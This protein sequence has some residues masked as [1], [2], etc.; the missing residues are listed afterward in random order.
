MKLN[1]EKIKKELK[2]DERTKTWLAR[3]VGISPQS[4]RYILRTGSTSKI[5]EISAALG[6]E[7]QEL[8]IW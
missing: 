6:V 7:P 2:D 4:I 5:D 3:K 8:V 1:T